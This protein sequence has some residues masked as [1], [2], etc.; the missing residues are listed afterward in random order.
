M[1]IWLTPVN[2]STGPLAA[3]SKLNEIKSKK[4]ESHFETGCIVEYIGS[5]L[6]PEN[7]LSLDSPCF[8]NGLAE[9]KV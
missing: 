1:Y 2:K 3:V 8:S 9:R 7:M 5:P 6:F 4:D